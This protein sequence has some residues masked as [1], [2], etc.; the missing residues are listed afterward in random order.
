MAEPESKEREC[1]RCDCVQTRRV[2]ES[3]VWHVNRKEIMIC[4]QRPAGVVCAQVHKNKHKNNQQT[5]GR[6]LGKGSGSLPQS[7][8]LVT[9]CTMSQLDND[10]EL[11]RLSQ[12]LN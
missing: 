7:S 3:G 12:S 6:A 8:T 9:S 1:C 4:G 2:N 10:G 5:T 11:S